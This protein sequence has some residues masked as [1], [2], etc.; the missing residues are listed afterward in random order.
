MRMNDIIVKKRNG[1]ALSKDEIDF[2]VGGVTDGSIPDYQLS[3]FLMAVYFKGMT[4]EETLLLTLSMAHSGDVVDLGEIT[5]IKAD[6]HS[7]GGVGDKTT[8]I[9]VPIVA[10]CGVKVAKMSGRGLGHT[11][12][13]LD[14]LEAIPNF[15]TE[16]S[17]EEFFD[18][19][20]RVGAC[21]VGQS[22]NLA[23][24]DKK[25][26][27]LRDVTGTV[28]EVSLIAASIMSKK[29]A[30]G[31][32]CILLDVKVGTGAFMKTV[33]DAMGLARVMVGIGTDAG[34]STEALIT[35][36]NSPLGFAIGN[37]LEVLESI[38]VLQGCGPSDLK[39]L[40]L[41]LAGNMLYQAGAGSLE[42]CVSQAEEVIKN[43]RAIAKFKEMAAA[44]GGDID[45]PELRKRPAYIYNV[46]SP[47]AGY[48]NVMDTEK[49]G[50]ASVIL[51]A[52]RETKESLIDYKAGIML[53][54]K[55]GDYVQKGEV[56]AEFHTNLHKC[57]KDASD[58]F[59]SGILL[60][61]GK[62]MKTPLIYGRVTSVDIEH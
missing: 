47:Q 16:L 28:D 31:S 10:A 49:C 45:S 6:K 35:D 34:K 41:Q 62:P 24:A 30:A 4:R 40:C 51:G 48:I 36:M 25:L 60:G 21:V 12:G 26:Y 17:Q 33:D 11:G 37:S 22:G 1:G 5:G 20:N 57:I 59:L 55:T 3:A 29:L 27:A 2:L 8:L 38:D 58:L 18:I 54:K 23:P 42:D 14:K 56:L 7:T 9:V 44:Q 13:T 43:G 53:K 50:A 46:V 15:K 19:V 39:Y 61:N 32:D 52:G